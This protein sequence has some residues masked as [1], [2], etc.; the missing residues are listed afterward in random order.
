MAPQGRAIGVC[1]TGPTEPK[2]SQKKGKTDNDSDGLQPTSQRGHVGKEKMRRR[3]DAKNVGQNEMFAAGHL[4]RL[5]SLVL[6]AC[7]MLGQ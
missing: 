7:Y 3:R 5:P 1:F 6:C 4:G 2:R